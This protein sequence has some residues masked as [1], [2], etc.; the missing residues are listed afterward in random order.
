MP[1]GGD[2]RVVLEQGIEMGR[3]SFRHIRIRH[4][5]DEITAVHVGGSCCYMGSGQLELPDRLNS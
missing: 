1:R 3:P 5:G 4:I 2:T